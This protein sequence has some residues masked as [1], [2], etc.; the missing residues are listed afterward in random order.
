MLF[1]RDGDQVGARGACSQGLRLALAPL[2]PASL[3]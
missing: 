1:T 2:E 3:M